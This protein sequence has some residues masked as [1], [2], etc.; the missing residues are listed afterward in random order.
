MLRSPR[1]TRFYRSLWIPGSDCLVPGRCLFSQ[2]GG[3][4]AISPELSVATLREDPSTETDPEGVAE[5]GPLLIRIA[6]T[7]GNQ[8]SS[9]RAVRPLQGRCAY[10]VLSGGI[11]DAQPP[12]NG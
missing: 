1:P 11:A 4:T 5:N 8:A 7:A 6:I 10:S 3:L 12:A 9:L 2:P